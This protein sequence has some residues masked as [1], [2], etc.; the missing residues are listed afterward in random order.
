M[1]V[2]FAIIREGKAETQLRSAVRSRLETCRRLCSRTEKSARATSCT[3]HIFLPVAVRRL[4]T[5]KARQAT[6]N[7]RRAVVSAPCALND[8]AGHSGIRQLQQSSVVGNWRAVLSVKK[9]PKASRPA[10][11]LR[12]LCHRLLYRG[13]KSKI[14]WLGIDFADSAM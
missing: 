5:S 9:G 13:I 14:L 12:C 3:R 10:D 2:L 11:R 4:V 8:I 6:T 7:H 1:A